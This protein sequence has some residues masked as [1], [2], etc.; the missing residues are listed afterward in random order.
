[1]GTL[2]FTLSFL[3]WERKETGKISSCISVSLCPQTRYQQKFSLFV[4]QKKLDDS[5]RFEV[6]LVHVGI[7]VLHHLTDRQ[8]DGQ[9]SGMSDMECLYMH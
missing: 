5:V 1:M 4:S 3:L 6:H 2:I 7:L 9:K 8:T